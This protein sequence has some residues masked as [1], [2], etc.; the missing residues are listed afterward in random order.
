M[1]A[2]IEF[3]AKLDLMG[4]RGP[5]GEPGSWTTIVLPKS[6]SAKLGTRAR[7]PVAG[8]INDFG[9]RSSAF[10]TSGGT[11]HIMVN[12]EMRE[13]AGV[14]AGDRARVVIEVD[15]RSRPVVLPPALRKALAGSKTAKAA[16][17]K[18][19]PSHR[20]EIA[21]YIAEA[22]R[23][24]TIARRVERTL[25]ALATGTWRPT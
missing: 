3:T 9:F 15:T 21:G 25:R 1:M 10:P 7:V 17:E 4:G 20:R 14:E 12:R 18:L 11:H 22:K 8:T 5:S 24:E 19:P 13:G 23:P 16:F 2:K 6:A